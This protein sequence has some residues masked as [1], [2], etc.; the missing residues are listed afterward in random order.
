MKN[1]ANIYE[2]IFEDDLYISSQEHTALIQHSLKVHDF[3]D[4]KVLTKMVNTKR[5]E[6]DSLLNLPFYPLYKNMCNNIEHLSCGNFLSL[7]R[8]YRISL[9][10][11]KKDMM[12]KI[13]GK[14]TE[15]LDP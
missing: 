1:L 7:K 9:K 14:K 13:L 15:K 11:P 4:L 2:F 3:R 12:L 10:P 6:I 5:N 8:N